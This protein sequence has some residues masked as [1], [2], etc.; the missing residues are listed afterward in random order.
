MGIVASNRFLFPNVASNQHCGDWNALATVC[1]RANINGDI[2]NATNQRGRISTMYAG[3]DVSMQDRALFFSHMGHS[4][5]VNSGTYQ[6]QLAVQAILK[7]GRHLVSMDK[8]NTRGLSCTD[9]F[10][11][12]LI[13]IL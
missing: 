9:Q 11:V 2:V 10:A 13:F 12:G 4:A 8:G 6:R 3:I 7:V 5:Q 1:T